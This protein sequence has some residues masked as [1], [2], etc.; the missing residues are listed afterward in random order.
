MMQTEPNAGVSRFLGIS[1]KSLHTSSAKNED[2]KLKAKALKYTLQRTAQTLLYNHEGGKQHRVCSCHRNVA[3]DGVSVYRDVSGNN[4]RFGNLM[5]CGS[6]WSCPV[7]AAKITESRRE[8]LQKAV[9]TWLIQG[10]SCLLLTSTFPH[11]ADMPLAELLEK[12]PKALQKFKNSR[13]YKN[14][15][16]TSVAASALKSKKD[17]PLKHIIEG[18]HPRLG[19][20]RS[21]EVSHGVNGWHPHTHEVLFMHDDRLLTDTAAVESLTKAWVVALINAGLG[22]DSKI[23]DML[24]HAMDIR[25]GDY[26][27]DYVN[28]F[29]REPVE[30]Q[31]W[32]IAHEVTKAN[33]KMGKVGRKF[34]NE[35]HYTPFQLL[36]FATDGDSVAAELFKE[37]SA[38]FEGRRM[39]YWTNGLK[40]WF[41][42]N[43]VEDE[44]LAVDQETEKEKEEE[45]VI[46]L[47]GDQW[48]LIIET[49]ARFEVLQ[50]AARGGL[51][52]VLS[53]IEDLKIRPKSYR[54]WFKDFARPDFSRFFH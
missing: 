15:F 51:D 32:T 2:H 14:I 5:T 9:S 3:S 34:G 48:K 54:G 22:D 28:K 38:C 4:A 20:V 33:S 16:G 13:T 49:N 39:N 26:V 29:G 11:E 1:A 27:A 6:V 40:D 42:I 47:D 36:G 25:G 30:L 10:G 52:S 12:F 31:G 35:F 45:F 46:R 24:L 41:N 7:C 37:F 8:D 17:T 43:E 23:N 19:T 21:L 50:A 44:D 18:T 53:L